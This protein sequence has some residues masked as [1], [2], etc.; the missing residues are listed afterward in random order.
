[1]KKIVLGLVL[2]MLLSS[3]AYA[4][5]FQPLHNLE[6]VS[7]NLL[8]IHQR[9]AG[10]LTFVASRL[11]NKNMINSHTKAASFFVNLAVKKHQKI[12]NYSFSKSLNNV[13]NKVMKLMSM[14]GE[15]SEKIY[16]QT[17]QYLGGVIKADLRVCTGIIKGLANR[18]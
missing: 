4:L 1:M 9:C 12:N 2:A 6:K 16:L 11:T 10:V 3:N 7:S 17:G 8:Y 14:Y 15:D 18:N 5:N 13:E